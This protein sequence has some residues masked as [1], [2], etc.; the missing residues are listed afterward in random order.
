M[1]PKSIR[2]LAGCLILL[3][4]LLVLVAW[5]A[6]TGALPSRVVCLL[7]LCFV[8]YA[9]VLR[10]VS[11]S[12]TVGID[13]PAAISTRIAPV[14]TLVLGSILLFAPPVLSDDL[15]RYLW[16][17]RV[18][19]NGF[20]PYAWAPD[21][22]LLS[23]LRNELWESVNHRSLA[24]IY[25]PLSQFLFFTMD[26]VAGEVWVPKALG[27]LTLVA[28]T[29]VVARAT[30]SSGAPFAIGLN[31]LLLS[32]CV[33]NGHL[34]LIVGLA[35]L[36][37]AMSLASGRY[38]RAAV[39]TC[40]A[41]GLKLVG[42]VFVP[43]FVR[44]WGWFVATMAASAL[45]LAPLALWSSPTEGVSGLGQFALTWRGNA[46]FYAVVEFLVGDAKIS[47]ALVVALV[48]AFGFVMAT[49]E[50]PPIRA[51]RLLVWTTLLVSPQVHPWYLAWL[52]PLEVASGKVAG[53]VWSAAILMTYA[54]LDRWV[55]D[56]V[57]VEQPA[58]LATQYA[59]VALALVWEW[60]T[61]RS[62]TLL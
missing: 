50:V 46:S 37:A 14:A 59:V 42:L 11:G 38:G 40:A 20:N 31:P 41:V 17:G 52:L 60:R 8:P 35:L 25:P 55:A 3:A 51:A 1:M 29:F 49:R 58:L 24:S 39:A 30:P 44:R 19:A 33:L 21:A 34:D 12:D 54:P 10:A 18:L 16:E 43:L 23:P 5:T 22:P 6:R 53:L 36:A 26:F 15:Y 9:G 32:E 28:S 57:W 47:R 7:C 13:A 45:L 62:D 48:A 2:W 61:A 56:R 4:G 27:L